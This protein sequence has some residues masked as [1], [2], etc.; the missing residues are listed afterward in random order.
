MMHL[1]YLFKMYLIFRLNFFNYLR[2][3]KCIYLFIFKMI[4]FTL[5]K[6]MY[7]I[8][9]DLNKILIITF[10]LYLKIFYIHFM[11]NLYFIL[12]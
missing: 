10:Y 3:L 2:L 9:F 8:L 11:I 6:C 5:L 4:S 1:F 7:I 12:K